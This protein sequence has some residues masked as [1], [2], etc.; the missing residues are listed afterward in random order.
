M[1]TFQQT[2]KLPLNNIII[3]IDNKQIYFNQTLHIP[4][5][6][7]NLPMD[8]MRF[9]FNED[10]FWRIELIQYTEDNKCWQVKVMDYEVKNTDTFNQQKSTK[11][12]DRLEFDKLDWQKLEPQ[13]SSYQAIKLIDSLYNH[14]I[15]TELKTEIPFHQPEIPFNK[16]AYEIPVENEIPRTKS[17]IASYNI[18][19]EPLTEHLNVNF[20]V[21]FQDATF[22][23]GYVNCKKFIKKV[24]AYIDFK[25]ENS[26]ILGEFDNIKLWFSKRLKTKKF[27]VSA[28][29]TLVDKKLAH[30]T[31]TS[32]EIEMI[33]SNLIESVKYDRTVAL[34]KPPRAIN[35]DKS[36]YTTEDI[37]QLIDPEV[38][39]GN[40]FN[41]SGPEIIK[42][43]TDTEFVRNRKQL[44]YLSD[45]KQTINSKIRYTLNP[46][47]GFLFLNETKA[48]YHF[49]WELLQSHA[50]YIWSIEKENKD[51]NSLYAKIEDIINIIKKIGR[52]EYK[53]IYKD[54]GYEFT[55]QSIDHQDI[56]IDIE[57]GFKKWKNKLDDLLA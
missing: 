9:R 11:Q 12:I 54:V 44:E 37:F 23:D 10:I 45:N 53:T 17:E 49:I 33:T 36:I 3:K 18:S 4:T 30:V 7:S 2:K 34:T 6:N 48:N 24:G 1:T 27:H 38:R 55:F 35:P 39:E 15:N 14:N 47:F 16:S 25:I 26:H 57:G 5:R 8:H 28:T 21:K 51:I 19:Q 29:I 40:I 56:T 43:L 46:L 32:P 41:Q 50:T 52:E 22:T 13:L 20:S 42:T 31:S